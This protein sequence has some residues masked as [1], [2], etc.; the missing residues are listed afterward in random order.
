MRKCRLDE[1]KNCAAL[2]VISHYGKIW[3]VKCS[4]W[5]CNLGKFFLSVEHCVPSV[6][7]M[8]LKVSQPCLA[9]SWAKKNGVGASPNV[10]QRTRLRQCQ[11]CTCLRS[12]SWTLCSRDWSCC[13]RE[14]PEMVIVL[15]ARGNG[16]WIKWKRID[17]IWNLDKVSSPIGV[18]AAV[19]K[20][21]LGT[22]EL[23]YKMSTIVVVHN[24]HTWFYPEITTVA[25]N[26][27]KCH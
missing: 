20:E 2:L 18:K 24:H 11:I 10:S 3:R 27:S 15:A 1:L 21:R 9:Q 14:S 25:Q 26:L 22:S 6:F 19:C 8:T 4:E 17:G 23:Q 16:G 12:A 13:N 5:L 7:W